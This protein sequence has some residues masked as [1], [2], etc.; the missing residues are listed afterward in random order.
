MIPL[1]ALR[2]ANAMAELIG[3]SPGQDDARASVLLRK[4][5]TADA[6]AIW[7]ELLPHWTSRDEFDLQ[8]TFSHRLAAI[9][10]ARLGEWTD[11]ADWL[12]G[13]R[14]RADDAT[15][16]TYCAGLLVDEGYARWKG[17]EVHAA[18]HCLV[19]GLIAIDRLPPDDANESAY[20]LRKYAGHTIMWIAN[21]AAGIPPKE[22]S[23]PP[24]ALCS[25]LEPIKEL[26][27][28]STPSD[29]IW[30]HLVEFE[31]AAELG[32]EQFRAH[33][34]QLKASRYGLIRFMFNKLRLRQ[35][36]RTL[37][38]DNFVE[39]VGD[40]VKSLSLCQSPT[41]RGTVWGR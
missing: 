35:R 32:D 30:A 23:A 4:G 12:H 3:R 22:F 25:S 37:V 28:P 15:Q 1:R 18:L 38:L 13:A 33:E 21:A 8:Q 16:E 7:R 20:L 2:F 5:D 19:H 9:A 10:A 27:S 40:W 41:T 36:L 39:V 29:L 26:E 17:G 11:A 14:A 24:P 31:F 6:L 34:A